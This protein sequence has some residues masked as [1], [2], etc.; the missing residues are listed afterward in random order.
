MRPFV[1]AICSA[2]KF[3][4]RGAISIYKYP[5]VSRDDLYNFWLAPRG[6]RGWARGLLPLTTGVLSVGMSAL[7]MIEPVALKIKINKTQQRN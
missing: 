4:K 1:T 2:S 6:S 3:W 7:L 5:F